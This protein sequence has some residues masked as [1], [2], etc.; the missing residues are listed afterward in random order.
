MTGK[1]RLEKFLMRGESG[2]AARRT[3]G[4]VRLPA[5]G[6]GCVKGGAES[7]IGRRLKRFFCDLIIRSI[8]LVFVY[9]CAARLPNQ[10]IEIKSKIPNEPESALPETG[11]LGRAT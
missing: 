9:C 11:I 2:W 7:G 5:K 8:N 10:N 3:I 6:M 1:K 4:P